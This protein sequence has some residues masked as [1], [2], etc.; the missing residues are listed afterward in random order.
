MFIKK[1]FHLLSDIFPLIQGQEFESLVN[2]IREHGLLEPILLHT[3]GCIIDGRNRYRACELLGIEPTYRTWNGD[4][5]SL[6]SFVVSMNLHRRH[7]NESQRAMVA[8]K[9]ASLSQGRPKENGQ[10][11]TFSQPEAAKMFNVSVRTIKHARKVSQEGTTELI[12]A[13]ESGAMPVSLAMT[14]TRE[15]PETQKEAGELVKAGTKP[16]EAVRQAKRN[17]NTLAPPPLEGKYRVIYADPPW[18]YGNRGLVGAY[19]HVENHFATLSIEQLC[20]LPVKEI[21]ESNSVLF[22]WATSPLLE[23]AFSVIKAWEFSYKTSFVWDKVKQNFGYYNSVR[24]ELLLICTRGSCLPDRRELFDSVVSIER[25]KNH[26]EKPEYF[27]R[28]IDALYPYGRRIELFARKEVEGWDAW[29][30][31]VNVSGSA[32]SRFGTYG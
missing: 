30:N 3:N 25:G 23:E 1:E 22:M 16:V 31:E 8:N 2:D 4:E 6:V 26:S 14:L 13:V 15:K 10:I 9:L 29:G 12:E 32:G 24:H 19:G 7:L 21:A 20:E 18:R 11:C 17:N 27:R 5:G 28:M